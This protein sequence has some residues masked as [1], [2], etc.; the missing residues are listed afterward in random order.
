MEC[1]EALAASLARGQESQALDEPLL[2]V[3]V[4][5]FLQLLLHLVKNLKVCCAQRSHSLESAD[6]ASR[7]AVADRLLMCR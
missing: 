1:K 3:A 2:A 7:R 5:E 4:A 6:K